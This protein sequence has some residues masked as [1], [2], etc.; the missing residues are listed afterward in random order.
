M[1]D[2]IWRFGLYNDINIQGARRHG[3]RV[4]TIDGV[5]K[6]AILLSFKTQ[7]LKAMVWFSGP[8]FKNHQSMRT[9][10]LLFGH[11]MA[12][13]YTP[14]WRLGFAGLCPLTGSTY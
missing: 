5:N 14:S 9:H 3:G 13:S 12:L 1:V 2:G 6:G 11:G 7:P 4:S 8:K 10:S